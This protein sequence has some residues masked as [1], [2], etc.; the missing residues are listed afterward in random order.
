MLNPFAE[1]LKKYPSPRSNH[2]SFEE[3]CGYYGA[4]LSGVQPAA[5]AIAANVAQP[6]V[7]YLKRAGDYVGGQ[8]RYYR[9][10]REYMLLGHDAFIQK[11]VTPIIRERCLTAMHNLERGLAKPKTST[12]PRPRKSG[13]VGRHILRPRNDYQAETWTIEIVQRPE[14][15]AYLIVNSPMSGEIP[16]AH[17][18]SFGPF[19]QARDAL[20]AAKD[21][22]TPED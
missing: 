16:H 22:L 19:D 13:L 5:I 15:F 11:Y 2:M 20:R 4:L 7:S 17:A 21:Q 14:G 9:V 6:T 3:A 18:Q 8:I 12:V 10:S 1:D